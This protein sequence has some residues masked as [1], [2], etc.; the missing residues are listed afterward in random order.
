M[1]TL[2][3]YYIQI[4]PS[5]E[6]ISGQLS[7]IMDGEASAA[8]SSAAGAFGTSFGGALATVGKVGVASFGL[9]TAAVGAGS[10]AL[11]KGIKD[12]ASYGDTIDKTS[13]K[14]GMTADAYQK[15]DY[16]MNL[17][18]TSMQECSMGMKTLTNKI[19]DAK[20]G[21]EAAQEM[22]AQL[23]LS[24]DDLNSMSREDVWSAT[25]QG[26]QQL[27]DST[28]R[29]ALANDL[30]GRSGQNMTPLFNMTNEELNEAI[31]NTEKYGMVMS[32]EAV[33]ASAAFQDSLT[34]L[35]GAFGGLKNNLMADFL[36]GVTTV[37]DGLTEIF[38][39]D[40]DKGLGMVKEGVK[41]FTDNL[42]ELI[43]QLTEIGGSILDALI[44]SL[45]E[46][47]ST[48]LTTGA[49]VI[50]QL[51]HSITENLPA[52]AS[53]A[54]DVMLQLGEAF[55]ELAPNLLDTGLVILENLLNGIGENL[56]TIIP[57]VTEVILQITSTLIGHIDELVAAGLTIFMGLVDGLIQAIP[58]IIEQIPVLLE[59]I[60][61]EMNN[62]LGMIAEAG[63]TLFSSL[64][65]ALP[66]IIDAITQ[67]LPEIIDCII[68][69]YTNGGLEQTI[70]A[71]MILMT[72][73]VQ[74]LPEIIKTLNAA[75][76]QIILS[77]VTAIGNRK[78]DISNAGKNLLIS[79]GDKISFVG[80][81]LKTKVGNL[82]RD[83]GNKIKEG[84]NDFISIGE[85]L[86]TGLW[87]GINN[88]WDWILGKVSDL[89]NAIVK[90]AKSIFQEH[91]PS[92][93][94]YDIGDNLG[95]GLGLGWEASMEKV[96]R[97][98]NDDLDY[99]GNITLSTQLDDT[100]ATQI[101]K[102]ATEYASNIPKSNEL[103]LDGMSFNIYE[104]VTLDGTAIKDDV[105]TYT[106]RRIGNEMR[107]VRTS[108]GGRYSVL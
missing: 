103:S 85:D 47:S 43:P 78:G 64:V 25:I 60:I 44:T 59:S 22:F 95:I 2:A 49:D 75:I 7:S 6:G 77:I 82:V 71:Y 48:L 72:S 11:T 19:D 28:E 96:N 57:M 92:K 31:E 56:D 106:I 27:E 63:V 24:M 68:D 102:A 34:T 15:W 55:V 108:R 79:I 33:K 50:I 84:V 81:D 42:S 100:A 93:V 52:L 70:Q 66:D 98:I 29:A 41:A 54:G 13:Q 89:G 40:S 12:V 3:D 26:M 61:T 18:G 107:A 37:M 80:N 97:E 30:F 104:T 73:M 23:G 14:V 58:M 99:E 32:D 46:N 5:A 8:G 10:V 1:A 45:S 69:Y 90:K 105:A 76:P 51:A 94:F 53:A 88:K 101:T 4:V 16:V 91:S 86:I 20:N 36:P 65:Q 38:A 39:G 62:S 67:A 87:N 17:A 35:Q 83:M 74:A 9:F 21:G